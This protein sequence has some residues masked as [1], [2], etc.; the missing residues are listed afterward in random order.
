MLFRSVLDGVLASD[1]ALEANL[2][3][4]VHVGVVGCVVACRIAVGDGSDL[5]FV[6]ELA[7]RSDRGN[8]GFTMPAYHGRVP[9]IL[10]IDD[11][12]S[13]REIASAYLERHGFEV[14]SASNGLD[15]LRLALE[16]N[17]ALVVLDIMLPALDGLEVLKRL[18]LERSIPVLLLSA[19][20]DEFDRVLGLELGADDYL[21]KP[22]SPRELVA[23]VKAVLRRGGIEI[24]GSALQH[25]ALRLDPLTRAVTL[26]GQGVELSALEFDL[27]AALLR[28]PGRVFTREELIAAVWGEDFAGVDRVVD[29]HISSLRR[30]LGDDAERPRFVATVR[31]VGYRLLEVAL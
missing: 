12:P 13:V 21:T 19:R 18:R 14:R 17:P 4:C 2:E 6:P 23:R 3:R 22:F 11:E 29:V 15:G 25:G 30:K 1:V 27:L 5:Q 28:S 24:A 7:D 9:L 16:T 8:R 31:G 26:G 20:G 10:V